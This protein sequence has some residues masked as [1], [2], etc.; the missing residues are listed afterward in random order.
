MELKLTSFF[1]IFTSFFSS[2]L[3]L[4][5]INSTFFLLFFSITAWI[6]LT[7]KLP[8][9]VTFPLSTSVSTFWTPVL[10]AKMEKG[11]IC[12]EI[13]TNYSNWI[14]YKLTWGSYEWL[15]NGT[16]TFGAMKIE[17]VNG[18]DYFFGF[19]FRFLSLSF[20]T[21]LSTALLLDAFHNKRN[22]GTSYWGDS[23]INGVCVL[24]KNWRWDCTC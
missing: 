17:F 12:K 14:L 13:K 24:G 20:L 10:H 19:R 16:S 2:S 1:S 6:F 21:H 15:L 4:G 9:T 23:S 7:S 22:K 3:G 11:Y 8:F 5:D 18:G